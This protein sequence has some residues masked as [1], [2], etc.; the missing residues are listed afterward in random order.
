[1]AMKM[2]DLKTISEMDNGRIAEAVRL[3]LKRIEEDCRDRPGEK[4]ARKVTLTILM[5]PELDES[6]RVMDT[7]KIA[8]DIKETVPKMKSKV[9]S[10]LA[11]GHG[12]FIN[13]ASE[14]D[15]RQL[16][17]DERAAEEEAAPKGPRREA[18][19]G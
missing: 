13:E 3:A 4:G 5:A 18:D 19:V 14:E 10:A 17:L 9:Y 11:R 2:L 12:L 8:F 16:T 1:M 15:A 6:C 7:A